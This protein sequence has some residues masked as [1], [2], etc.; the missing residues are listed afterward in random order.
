MKFFAL[1]LKLSTLSER[2]FYDKVQAN[3]KRVRENEKHK[4]VRINNLGVN[5]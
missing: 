5:K 4:C 2:N 1:Y 3:E